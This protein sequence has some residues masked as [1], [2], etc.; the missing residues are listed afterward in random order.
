MLAVEHVCFHGKWEQTVREEVWPECQNPL[1]LYCKGTVPLTV[2][3]L[4]GTVPPV[5]LTV[6]DLKGTVPPVTLTAEIL[7]WTLPNSDFNNLD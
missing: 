2:E 3:D 6:E 7:K 1:L 5:T 4:K